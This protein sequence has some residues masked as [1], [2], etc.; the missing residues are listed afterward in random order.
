MYYFF[1]DGVVKVI[2]GGFIVEGIGFGCLI[3]I[4]EDVKVDYLYVILDM[5][6]LFLVFDVVEYEGLLFGGLFVINL[7]GVCRLVKDMGLGYIIVII[8]CDYGICSQFKFYNFDFLCFK[9]FLVLGWL[10]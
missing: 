6:V 9:N 1:K 8:F 5:E 7:V 10:E 2:D 4:V 3:V